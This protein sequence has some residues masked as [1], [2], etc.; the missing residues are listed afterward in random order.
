MMGQ[1][2]LSLTTSPAL[3]MPAIRA[4]EYVRMSTEHQQYSTENQRDAIRDYALRRGM[5]VTRSYVD[6]GKSGLRIERRAA[7]KQLLKDVENREA[8]FSAILV[9]DVSRWGRFQD[10]DESAYYEYICR[11]T[12]IQVH[13][14]AEPFENDGSAISAIIKNLKRA[15]AAEYSRELSCKVFIGMCRIIELGYRQG[16]CAGI[17]L[18]RMLRD[19]NGNLKGTLR[20]GEHK[21]ISTDRVILVPGPPEEVSI[22][23]S[24]YRM[25]VEENRAKAEIARILKE[26]GAKTEWGHRWNI[27]CIHE[28][29][30]NEKYIGNNVYYR[31]SFKLQKRFVRNPPEMWIRKPGAFDPIISPELFYKAQKIIAERR[32]RCSD[33]E[34]LDDL[35]ALLE[36]EGRVSG[37]LIT[38]AEDMFGREMYRQRFDTLVTAFKLVGYDP[39]KDFRYTAIN[40]QL[41]EL[42][43]KIVAEIIERIRQLGGAVASDPVTGVLEI[44]NE[45]TAS[46]AVARFRQWVRPRGVNW[47]IPGDRLKADVAIIVRMDFENREPRDYYILPRCDVTTKDLILR[48]RNGV[49]ID[50]YRFSNL[51]SFFEMIRRVKAAEVT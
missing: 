40:R 18:R 38:Q 33:E 30:T 14:C 22:V 43:S 28:V 50:A 16:G 17:G 1:I 41:R 37:P 32:R 44:N 19:I 45:F 51:D 39:G 27:R 48:E 12:N 13:Y 2:D 20:R 24:I 25:F 36:R 26:Q 8:D 47:F 46:V 6:A 29:L 34:L 35:R 15:M 5:V 9:Y 49:R 31:T 10:T 23:R 42:E 11:R 7:L 21:S 4:A 3:V